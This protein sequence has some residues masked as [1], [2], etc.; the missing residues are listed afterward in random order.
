[1]VLES[2]TWIGRHAEDF[3]IAEL[4]APSRQLLAKNWRWKKHEI[5]AIFIEM[6]TVVFLEVKCRTGCGIFPTSEMWSPSLA[7]QQRIVRAAHAFVRL[8]STSATSSRFDL[9][10]VRMSKNLNR[11]IEFLH[12]PDA[13]DGSSVCLGRRQCGQP[14]RGS[15]R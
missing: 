12:V 2:R 4:T 5:D 7:Q 9:A 14:R 3:A 13:F 1:M 10:F 6:D 15:S 11:V 8:N